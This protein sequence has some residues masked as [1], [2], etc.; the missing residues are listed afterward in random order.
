MAEKTEY[1]RWNPSKSHPRSP[2]EFKEGRFGRPHRSNTLGRIGNAQTK[3]LKANPGKWF[4][5]R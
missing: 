3:K 5:W 1:Q 2:W 4:P